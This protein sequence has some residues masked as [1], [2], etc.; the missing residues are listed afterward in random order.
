[1]SPGSPSLVS[2]AKLPRVYL[3]EGK[4]P[5]LA[6]VE[7]QRRSAVGGSGVKSEPQ[8]PGLRGSVK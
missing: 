7:M 6:R 8:L 4:S 3:D 5:V 1:M 2:V